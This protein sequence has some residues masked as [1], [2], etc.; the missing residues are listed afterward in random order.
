MTNVKGIY[1]QSIRGKRLHEGGPVIKRQSYEYWLKSAR[2]DWKVSRHLFEK[3][4]YS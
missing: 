3:G 2:E 4:D 1:L